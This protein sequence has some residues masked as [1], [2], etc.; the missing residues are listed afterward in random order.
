MKTL[1]RQTAENAMLVFFYLKK[2]ASM[3]IQSNFVTF[4]LKKN[5]HIVVPSLLFIGIPLKCS[6]R[7]VLWENSLFRGPL[8]AFAAPNK[9]HS[10]GYETNFYKTSFEAILASILGKV[11][12]HLQWHHTPLGGFCHARNRIQSKRKL[13]SAH[14][15]FHTL[16]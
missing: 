4:F 7:E 8:L 6:W 2:N 13:S 3:K 12:R 5:P 10:K 11:C 14:R 15:A 9:P 16:I 1:R